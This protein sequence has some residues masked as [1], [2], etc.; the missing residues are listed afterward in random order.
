MMAGVLAAAAGCATHEPPSSVLESPAPPERRAVQAAPAAQARPV[1]QARAATPERAPSQRVTG[2]ALVVRLLPAGLADRSGWASDIHSAMMAL[3]IEPSAGSICAVVAITG[4]ES[5][6]RADPSV[7]DLAAIAHREIEKRRERA[8]IPKFMVH[9]ALALPSSDGRSYNERLRA[10]TTER[11]LSDVFEDFAG[12]VPLAKTFIADRNPVRTGGPMQVSVAFAQAH[13]ATHP[14]PYSPSA[15]IREEV[16]SRR[17]GT[18]FGIAHLLHYPAPYDDPVYRFADFNAGRFASRNAAF[19]RAV[20]ELSGMPLELDGDVLRYEQGQPARERSSTELA[21]LRLAQRL[22]MSAAEIRRD[23]ELGLTAQ[24]EHSKLYAAVFALADSLH[25]RPV[26]RALLPTI[27]LQTAKTTRKLT[28]DGF[29]LRVAERYR[30][31]LA[32]A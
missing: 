31:C 7:P 4:Q 6:F 3:G 5:G 12:R 9:A 26:P 1:T 11:Q 14:Y 16:F 32:R 24:F 13:A 21:T 27:V 8:S 17:G 28:S 20:R 18:Y 23:L 30:T 29:A 25:G 19:Q 2:L 10:A 22:H 15:S